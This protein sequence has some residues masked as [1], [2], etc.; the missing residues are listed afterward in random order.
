MF[1]VC[2]CTNKSENKANL[3][4]NVYYR[5]TEITENDNKTTK[6]SVIIF[7]INKKGEFENTIGND[8]GYANALAIRDDFLN[9]YYIQSNV[10]DNLMCVYSE[11]VQAYIFED[12]II[13]IAKNEGESTVYYAR[14]YSIHYDN[15]RIVVQSLGSVS[16]LITTIFITEDYAKANSIEIIKI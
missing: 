13:P 4:N 5:V 12:E 2:G 14:W 16:K 10:S 1:S 8:K 6:K 7:D 15:D 3:I 9:Y 11:N